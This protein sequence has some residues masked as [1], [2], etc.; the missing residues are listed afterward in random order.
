MAC[1]GIMGDLPFV[2]GSQCVRIGSLV[3]V[4][5]RD[6]LEGGGGD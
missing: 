5:R 1:R 6:L 3:V 2:R 4:D